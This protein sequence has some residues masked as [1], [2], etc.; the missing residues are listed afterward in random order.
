MVSLSWIVNGSPGI[1]CA[2]ITINHWTPNPKMQITD[3]GQLSTTYDSEKV[4][5][6]WHWN[7]DKSDKSDHR[8][9]GKGYKW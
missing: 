5:S 6:N 8:G 1:S 3:I 7:S 2:S 4:D 9:N